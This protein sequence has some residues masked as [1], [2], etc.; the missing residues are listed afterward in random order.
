MRTDSILSGRN[1]VSMQSVGKEVAA[2]STHVYGSCLLLP[3]K[4]KF[5]RGGEK[6]CS[7]FYI[8][9]MCWK[10]IIKLAGPQL[11]R[12]LQ[13]QTRG[14]EYCTHGLLHLYEMN[15]SN[16]CHTYANTNNFFFFWS[17]ESLFFLWRI[18]SWKRSG[19]GCLLRTLAP[20]LTLKV[21]KTYH[22]T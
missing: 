16:L 14:H 3:L 18:Q 8:R 17:Y 11:W 22:Q 19:L 7:R 1:T 13:C 21:I 5:S 9:Q 20:T 2:T 15:V 6:F 10:S 12:W 4:L